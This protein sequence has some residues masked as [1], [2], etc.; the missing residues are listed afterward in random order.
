MQ[1][2]LFETESD[3]SPL[4]VLPI[5]QN[6]EDSL[7]S[8]VASVEQTMFRLWNEGWHSCISSSQGKDSSV[9]TAI[10]LNAAV[11]YQEQVGVVPKF[12]IITGNTLIE[13]P[14][15][16]DYAVG[17]LKKIE[18]FVNQHKIP[19]RIE[20]AIPSLSNQY[21]LSI[22]GGRTIA[23]LSDNNSKCS[24]MLKVSPINRLKKNIFKELGVKRGAKICTLIGKRF[25]ESNTRSLNMKARGERPDQ[26]IENEKGEFILSPIA[27]FTLDDVFE[28]IGETTSGLRKSYSDF[29]KLTEVYRD[30]QAGECIINYYSDQK[31]KSTAC[32]ARHGCHQCL[33]VKDNKSLVNMLRQDKYSFM[34]PLN[35][36]RN[37]IKSTHYDWSKRNWLARTVNP[38]LSINIS[39]NAYSP[40]HC[41]TLLKMALSIDAN[42]ADRAAE[43][44]EEPRFQ[45]IRKKDCIAIDVYYNRYGYQKGLEALYWWDQIHNKGR[46]FMPPTQV[47]DHPATPLPATISVPFGDKYYLSPHCGL[48]DLAMQTIDQESVIVKK[49]QYYT[50]CQT[51]EEFE[52][53]EEGAELFF[54]FE[55]E[56]ALER[57][58][59]DDSILNPTAAFHYLLRTGV[60][61]LHKGGHSENDRMLRLA[62]QI[63]RHGIRDVLHD[64]VA[65]VKKLTGST[66]N[67]SI[68][69]IQE[70]LI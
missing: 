3:T 54:E 27:M 35:D 33:R 24:E 12:V 64:P 50:D 15:I 53:D 13:N 65:L 29:E 38:D 49:G 61:K 28:F 48:R 68:P 22:I 5:G 31:N 60:V 40:N 66:A 51:G 70:S 37:Y 6:F 46:R 2:S 39:P 56:Y 52:I 14:I 42:E 1:N 41:L 58:H 63:W 67:I 23:V 16:E 9:M 57:F 69:G 4:Q 30:S 19:A 43:E 18:A 10:V 8:K 17:E 26:P 45:L 44:I 47:V 20:V 7:D 32:G 34:K 62:D 59:E 25:L 55:L 11:K 21:L 36:F